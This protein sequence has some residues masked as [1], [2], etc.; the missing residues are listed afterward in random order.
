MNEFAYGC[1]ISDHVFVTNFSLDVKQIYE[2]T[3]KLFPQI[4]FQI[5]DFAY[6][7]LNKL[8]PNMNSLVVI[9]PNMFN[10]NDFD[11]FFTEIYRIIG[12]TI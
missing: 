8:L 12:F 10:D 3:I 2:N 4:P 5:H 1:R 7:N 11:D 9:I 6:D